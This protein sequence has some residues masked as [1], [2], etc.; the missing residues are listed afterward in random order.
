MAK[1]LSLMNAGDRAFVRAVST[2]AYCNPFLPERI[3]C[4]RTA[5][6]PDYEEAG[7]VWHARADSASENPNMVKLGARVETVA[8]RLREH[9]RQGRRHSPGDL[10]LYEDLVLYLLYNRY[11]ADLYRLIVDR[12]SSTRKIGFYDRFLREFERFL[13]LPNLDLAAGRDPVQI[14]ASFFQIRRAFHFIFRNII[15]A[16]MPAAKLRAAAWQSIFTRDL[17][18]YRRSLYDRMRDITTLI[19]GPS[20]TGK[21]LVAQAIGLS[22]YIPF[23]A[24]RLAF[25]G[26]YTESF[27]PLNL[28]ALSP[29]LIESELF[30]HR[31][32]AFTGAAQDRTGW[33]EIC[34]PL[35]SVFLDE[36]A[37][38]EVS[39]QVK[40][41]RVLQSRTFHRLGE[42]RERRFE[43]KIIAATNRDL[44]AEMRAGRFR[45]DLYYRLC[46]DMIETPPLVEHLRDSPD[47]VSNLVLF[48]AQRIVGESEAEALATEAGRW[49]DEHLGGDYPWP[50]NVRE[51]EQCVR[52]VMIRGEY[53]P[54]QPRSRHA[55]EEISEA[56]LAG[57][58]SADELLRRYCTLV[59]LRT[60]SYLETARRLRLDRRTV[61]AKIDS[62]LLS[63]WREAE[64]SLHRLEA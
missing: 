14:F 26:D 48:I 40:L 47:D 20:G 61:K 24:D 1:N 2:L 6:G 59:Y 16:S 58:L 33:L 9:I 13:K 44:A 29:T 28:S 60:G 38:V 32:G 35:G 30:G 22:R 8:D 63:E 52:N 12:G 46:S 57:S 43:G 36:I 62:N 23:D 56:F 15:G 3:A 42:T 27:Y 53:R 17:R 31:R 10:P 50:G 21:E 55:R 11:E 51:L 7:A 4:E 25:I 5:L 41:L 45:E 64:G 54:Q 34:P 18:R 19:S 49:I 39:I 37:E